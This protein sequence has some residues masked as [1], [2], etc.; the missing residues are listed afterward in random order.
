MIGL[1]SMHFART[2]VVL[3]QLNP[4]PF[5]VAALRTP[6]AIVRANHTLQS[7]SVGAAVRYMGTSISA[8]LEPCSRNMPGAIWQTLRGGAVSHQQ[9][10]PVT[11]PV[12]LIG[13]RFRQS[14]L[15]S[16]QKSSAR[17]SSPPPPSRLLPSTAVIFYERAFS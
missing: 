4:H 6:P 9:G 2:N 12:C 8:P 1:S 16:R 5:L 17:S 3:R 10:T 14:S 15:E 7:A 11:L 13:G